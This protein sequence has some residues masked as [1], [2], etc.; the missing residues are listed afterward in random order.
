MLVWVYQKTGRVD[1]L[2]LADQAFACGVQRGYLGTAKH[3]NQQ[4]RWSGEYVQFRREI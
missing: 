1:Y 3:F 4:Y 2:H